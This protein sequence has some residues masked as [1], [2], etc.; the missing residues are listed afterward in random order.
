[1]IPRVIH[2]IWLGDKLPPQAYLDT[3][4][5][6]PGFKY[7]LWTEE[8]LSSLSMLNQDKYEYF[9]N[10]KVYHGA[11]DIA[12]VE[13]LFHYGGF[14]VDADTK[15]LR[16]IP[17]D[18]FDNNFFAVE[19]YPSPK[20]KYRITNGHMGSVPAGDLIM[21]YRSRIRKAKKWEP[22]WSTIGGTMLTDIVSE[23]FKN[24]NMSNITI[25]KGLPFSFRVNATDVDSQTY[26]G[27]SFN[28]SLSGH[29]PLLYQINATSGLITSFSG[30]QF[31]SFSRM[32]NV[33]FILKSNIWFEACS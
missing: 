14:Y 9:L 32:M 12:R 22:C 21:E 19:A 25:A 31:S 2:Q 24:N 30:R 11:A 26:E 28:F 1:M 17:T 4:K 7:K 5:L 3:W 6:L 8:E 10:K 20:W 27:E 23:Q 15:R 29:D 33:L 13:I 16:L 18:W